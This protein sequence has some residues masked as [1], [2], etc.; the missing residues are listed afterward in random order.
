MQKYHKIDAIYK[1][2]DN[3]CRLTKI[4]IKACSYFYALQWEHN[5][6]KCEPDE[7]Q[8]LLRSIEIIQKQLVIP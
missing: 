6:L 5:Q 1:R 4:I 8:G 3:M 2:D 7:I